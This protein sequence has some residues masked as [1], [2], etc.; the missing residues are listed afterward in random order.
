MML[1]KMKCNM[2]KLT[3]ALLSIFLSSLASAQPEF[4]KVQIKVE[5]VAGSVYVLYGEGGN[6]GVSVGS[7]GVLLVDDQYAPLAPKIKTALTTISKGQPVKFILNTHWHPD[8]TGGNEV[9]GET[10]PIIAQ[11]NVRKRMITGGL[12]SNGRNLQPATKGALPV[13]TFNEKLTVHINDEDIRALHLESG[14]TDGDV[15]VY[16]TRSN[17]VHMGDQFVSGEFL[18]FVD[19]NSGGNLDGLIANIEKVMTSVPDDVKVIPGHGPI[20]AK[21]DLVAFARMLKDTRGA[22]QRAQQKKSSFEEFS[23]DPVFAPYQWSDEDKKQFLGRLYRGLVK[24][25]NND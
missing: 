10:A 16:F 12:L 23:A 14:H 13:V 3:C 17:V 7:D 15:V 5:H 19:F 8:H 2:T 9:F 22:V 25:E 6:I 4:D 11:E 21:S 18:P 1:K 20:S 24:A